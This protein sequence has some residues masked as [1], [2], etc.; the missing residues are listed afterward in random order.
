LTASTV[1]SCRTRATESGRSHQLNRNDAV[2]QTLNIIG[3]G[4]VGRVF[5][6]LFSLQA[7]LTVQ[8]VL[9]RSQASA[10]AALA[11]I[12]SGRVVA[13]MHAM[14]RADIYLLAVSDDQ[15]EHCAGQL[16]QHGLLD[17]ATVVFHCSGALSS[18]ALAAAAA[19]GAACAS[20][21]PVRSFADPARVASDFDATFCS[22]E[23]DARALAVLQPA[24]LAIGGRALTIDASSKTLYHAASVFASNYLSSLADVALRTYAAAGIEP[25]LAAE[26]AAPLMR[27]TLDNILRLGPAAALS[28]PIARGD[29]KTVARQQAALSAWD[30]EAGALY[31][32]FVAPTAALARRKAAL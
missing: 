8:D 25:A 12:G 15:I 4:H 28:G 30:S 31:Q 3:A 7:G 19:A 27:E 10:E 13:D 26:L 21:H 29:F 9:N 22:L 1:S 17:A 11:F 5:G 2:Q 18:Q 14:R 32:A 20:L 23:G 24:V 6:R 16:A